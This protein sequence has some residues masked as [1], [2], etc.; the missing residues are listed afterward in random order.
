MH[1]ICFGKHL[2]LLEASYGCHVVNE[3]KAE[4]LQTNPIIRFFSFL[5]QKFCITHMSHMIWGILYI[6]FLNLYNSRN[7]MRLSKSNA[8]M[9][10]EIFDTNST[11]IDCLVEKFLKN[12]GKRLIDR[13]NSYQQFLRFENDFWLKFVKIYFILDICRRTRR[14]NASSMI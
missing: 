1:Y 13:E 6:N 10:E 7:H 11:E 5:F 8:D 2:K 12:F 9:W 3:L 14:L 4:K